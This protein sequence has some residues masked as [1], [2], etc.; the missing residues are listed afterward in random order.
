MYEVVSFLVHVMSGAASLRV[1][2]RMGLLERGLTTSDF[3]VSVKYTAA[4]CS[5]ESSCSTLASREPV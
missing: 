1:F 3:D 5:L 4:G 2:T